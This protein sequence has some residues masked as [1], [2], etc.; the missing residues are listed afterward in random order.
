MSSSESEGF[1]IIIA[2]RPAIRIKAQINA[3]SP[4]IWTAPTMK[5][6]IKDK[7]IFIKIRMTLDILGL[8]SV[9]SKNSYKIQFLQDSIIQIFDYSPSAVFLILLNWYDSGLLLTLN[10]LALD[11]LVKY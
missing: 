9:H 6:K 4:A 3:G 8:V 1:H 7:R 5:R 2:R 10:W 11:L